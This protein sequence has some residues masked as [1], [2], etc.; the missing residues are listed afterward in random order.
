MNK[1]DEFWSEVDKDQFFAT[2][3]EMEDDFLMRACDY[4]I[5]RVAKYVWQHQQEKIDQLKKYLFQIQEE[6]KDLVKQLSKH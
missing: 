2:K 1:F 3:E 4:S 6:N 5:D